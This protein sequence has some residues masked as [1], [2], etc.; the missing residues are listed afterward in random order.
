MTEHL[1][2]GQIERYLARTLGPAEILAFHGH[3]GECAEC[4]KALEQALAAHSLG[5]PLF[6]DAVEAHLTEEE[7][8]ALVARRMPAD[9]AAGAVRHVAACELCRD[10]VAAMES[11]RDQSAGRA[12]RRFG[13]GWVTTAAIAAGLLVAAVTHFWRAQ[14][15]APAA[16]PVVAS[17]T[18][19][20][21][22]IALD[23][24]GAL[25]GME[26][27]S[28][29]ERGWVREALERKALPAGPSFAPSAP[30]VLL[31]PEAAKPAFS[32][33]APLD[34]RVLPDRPV[35]TWQ[36]C[37]GAGAYQ[38]VVTNENL[39]PLARSGRISATAW[40]PDKP[41]PRGPVLL[42]QVRAWRGAEM[43]S[44]PAP[45]APPAR[46]QIAAA[47]AAQRLAQLRSSPHPS[48]LLAAVFCEREGLRDEA[49][50]E[51]RELAR[52]NPGSPLV[53]ALEGR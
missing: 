41:L 15:G 32:L 26:S 22:T 14:S 6:H 50:A 11:V 3:A 12:A 34:A 9:R 28:A 21:R 47:D 51:L 35:F 19:G 37:P 44:A 52:E 24:S 1:S 45:P 5:A 10:S 13:A 48:H 38:V 17:V 25:R 23:S 8:V 40:Q 43:L 53:A 30:G 20:G 46:F 7:M 39:D 31:G 16:P 4:R 49:A 36:A 2:G 18:D 42:W 29:E 27:A 33:I